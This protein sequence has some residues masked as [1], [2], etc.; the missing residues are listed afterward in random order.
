MGEPE[1]LYELLGIDRNATPEEIRSAYFSAARRVHPD[2]NPNNDAKTRFLAIQHAYDVL[3]QPDQRADYDQSLPLESVPEGLNYNLR[4]S[5]TVIPEMDSPQ[6]A[7][8]LIEMI[9]TANLDRSQ[10]PPVFICL[11][12]DRSTSMQGDRMDMV[13]RNI[14]QFIKFLRPQDMIAVVTFGDRADVIMPATRVCDIGTADKRV[15]L[16]QTGGATEI[17]RGISAGIIELQTVRSKK[18]VRKLVL[19]TDGHTYGDEKGCLELAK[20]AA[21][22]GI[23]I[24]ALGIGAEWNDKFLD[25]L[26]SF[27]GGSTV[28][29]SSIKDLT[30][31]FEQK[32]AS[33]GLV[34]AKGLEFV[35]SSD[36]DVHL[37]YAFRLY[38]E[39]G[40]LSTDG[41]L[42]IGDLHYGKSISVLLEFRIDK[43][44]TLTSP[45]RL[46]VGHLTME[47]PGL[48][49]S[50]RQ[51]PLQIAL[52]VVNQPEPELPPAPVV[53]ALARLTLY[54]LQERARIEVEE[55]N[56]KSAARHL[57][58]LAT[59]LLSIGDRELVKTV[60]KE[61]ENIKQS[62]VFTREGDKKIKY[63]TRALLLPAGMELEEK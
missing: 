43:A 3:S 18:F 59:H 61:A 15:S 7:Y 45:K 32:M 10:F 35:Y 16:I 46:A 42:K 21:E 52:P 55:G 28:Y 38:P 39:L 44:A 47:I 2:V 40:P 60:L 54:R 48:G 58:Y 31:F 25:Q 20:E 12:I 17:L 23:S 11:V 14:Q 63:G 5:R 51:V 49:N 6:L 24:D 4:Y 50:R 33:L 29:I 57:Q 27:S 19:M 36:P 9:C 22:D 62:K 34:F 1:D 26:V 30:N 8:A 37:N 53:D 13:K 41:P 56:T